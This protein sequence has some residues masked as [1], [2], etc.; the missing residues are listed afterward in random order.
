LALLL[1]LPSLTWAE[2]D[3]S[4]GGLI[5]KRMLATGKFTGGCGIFEMMADFQKRTQMDGGDDFLFRFWTMEAARLGMTLKEYAT[6][7]AAAYKNY[8]D[9]EALADF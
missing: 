6:Q 7:C 5:I 2:D 3:P 4:D 1:T 8:K 9:Y